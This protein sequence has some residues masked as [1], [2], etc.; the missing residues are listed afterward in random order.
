MTVKEPINTLYGSHF[1]KPDES[2]PTLTQKIITVT[3]KQEL[4]QFM[5]LKQLSY[6][7]SDPEVTLTDLEDIDDT[8]DMETAKVGLIEACGVPS[9]LLAPQNNSLLVA[10]S[11]ALKSTEEYLQTLGGENKDE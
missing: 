10:I 8:I 4:D 5:S 2:I 3:S 11:T 1:H 7:I 9:K 6:N